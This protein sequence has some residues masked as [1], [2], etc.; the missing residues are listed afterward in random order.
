MTK[1][2]KLWNQ[3]GFSDPNTAEK[4]LKPYLQKLCER[5]RMIMIMHYGFSE[6]PPETLKEIGKKFGIT[7][8][9]VQSIE[10]EAILE[11]AK[12]IKKNK[13][14][15]ESLKPGLIPIEDVDFS[16][17]I[18]N[19]LK[20][21]NIKTLKDLTKRS[22]ELVIHRRIGR[23]RLLYIA[24]VLANYGLKLR[25]VG[26]SPREK[27]IE[28]IINKIDN[29]ECSLVHLRRLLRSNFESEIRYIERKSE[30]R[31]ITKRAK[32]L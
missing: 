15:S 9:R 12:E 3:V 7:G 29:I 13:I 31:Y 8:S 26:L 20:E 17:S 28:K 11:I 1:L 10:K 14:K 27:T 4:Q 2:N 5:S 18:T 32:T 22:K 19:I 25:E 21:L 23:V 16:T 6:N 24:Q 30:V